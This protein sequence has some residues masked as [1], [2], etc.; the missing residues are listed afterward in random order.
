M[1]GHAASSLRST[2]GGN[3]ARSGP[4][5]SVSWAWS[6]TNAL[7]A[8]PKPVLVFENASLRNTLVSITRM[9][10]GDT[11]YRRRGESRGSRSAIDENGV[12][13]CMLKSLRIRRAR[14]SR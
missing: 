13:R 1:N 12:K 4:I 9:G 7:W 11:G 6:A 2:S 5:S 14:S 8:V 10:R 3:Q